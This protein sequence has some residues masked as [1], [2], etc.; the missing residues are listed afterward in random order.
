LA[1][2]CLYYGNWAIL[3]GMQATVRFALRWQ[4]WP[5]RTRLLL[6]RLL[7]RWNGDLLARGEA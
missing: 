7:M 1:C 2:C 6:I 3:C 4:V 5:P